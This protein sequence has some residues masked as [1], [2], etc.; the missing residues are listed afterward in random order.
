VDYELKTPPDAAAIVETF[1]GF[2]DG[3]I[4]SLALRSQDRFT[5]DGP[6]AT[7]IAHH[8]SGGFDIDVEFAHYNYGGRL[9]P[10]DRIVRAVFREVRDINLD[11]TGHTPE[12]WPI[13]V[14]EFPPSDDLFGFHITRS[15]LDGAEWV[16]SL[17]TWFRFGA[18]T[19]TEI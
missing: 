1:N 6:E 4:R 18:A 9:Q 7:D 17:Q 15:R 10:I 13:T 19:F 2:H 12:Q 16:T 3:F 8:T 14:V 11:L 5:A